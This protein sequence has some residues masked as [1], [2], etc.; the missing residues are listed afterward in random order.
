[1]KGKNTTIQTQHFEK[2][3][4]MFLSTDL[5]FKFGYIYK[6]IPYCCKLLC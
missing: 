5:Y 1:M 3:I 2:I 6:F 4:I